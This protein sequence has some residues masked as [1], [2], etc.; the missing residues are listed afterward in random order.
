MTENELKLHFP[1]LEKDLI[2]EMVNVADVK[3][4]AAGEV[5]MRTGQNIRSTL[6]VQDGPKKRFEAFFEYS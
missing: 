1:M 2:R 5:L 4:L 3:A 6:L